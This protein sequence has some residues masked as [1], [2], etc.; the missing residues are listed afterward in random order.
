MKL[1]LLKLLLIAAILTTSYAD[2]QPV[3]GVWKGK[4]AGKKVELKIIKK[5]DSLTGTS[6]YYQS[7]TSYRRYSI[8]GYFDSQDNSVVWWDDV[9][10]EE[11]NSNRWLAGKGVSPYRSITD[12]NCPG[13]TTMYLY[14]KA[15]P[16]GDDAGTFKPVDLQ[17][18]TTTLFPDE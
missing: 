8:K 16:K 1:S 9:L 2:A 18:Y 6:Y 13:G 15:A 14:G 3:T 10:I 17:K 4:I 11:K 7:P 12:F 5:G